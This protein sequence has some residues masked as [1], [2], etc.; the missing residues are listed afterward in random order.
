MALI[1]T[2][3]VP[4]STVD[5]TPC[6]RCGRGAR[7]R[8]RHELFIELLGVPDRFRDLLAGYGTDDAID[9]IL[10]ARP[11]PRGWSALERL[12]HVA[13]TFHSAARAVAALGDGAR[14]RS[15]IPVHIDAPRADANSAPVRVVLGYLRTATVDLGHAA[16]GSEDARAQAIVAIA[17]HQA[18]HHLADTSA[19]LD[20]ATER[21]ARS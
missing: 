1:D 15:T 14:R 8:T 11:D 7:E 20:T 21:C 19:L 9:P 4:S 13:D 3:L 12:T 18:R 2:E 17:L 10:R 16:S 6:S 5:T